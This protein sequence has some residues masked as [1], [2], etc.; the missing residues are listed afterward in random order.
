MKRRAPEREP[1]ILPHHG[2]WPEIDPSAFIAPSA[3]IIGEVKIGAESSVWFQCVVRGDVESITI[4]KR[5]NVQD[6][7]MLH[8]DRRD[9][10]LVIGDEVTVGHKVTLHGCTIGNRVLVGMDAVVMNKAVIGDDS[11]VAAGALVTE[12]KVFPPKS[13]II[14]SP[15]KV[16]REL[17]PEELAFLTKS[18]NNYVGDSREY[19]ATLAELSEIEEEDL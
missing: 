18:A 2:K 10:P 1:L 6:L 13:L 19:I 3:D 4:G 16:S 5:T 12:G 11:I 15:A 9:C 17:K 8:V 14:G 7:T